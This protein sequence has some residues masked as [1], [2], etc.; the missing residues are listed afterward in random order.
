M[1]RRTGR[2]G[3]RGWIMMVVRRKDRIGPGGQDGGRFG[4]E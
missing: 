2:P 4:S 1:R 3:H